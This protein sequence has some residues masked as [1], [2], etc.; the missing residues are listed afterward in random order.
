MPPPNCRYVRSLM[1]TARENAVRE[2]TVFPAPVFE[3]KV[4]FK[5]RRDATR[6]AKVV[7]TDQNHCEESSGPK[8][9]ILPVVPRDDASG[10]PPPPLAMKR[11]RRALRNFH[12]SPARQG[13][14]H[15][16]PTRTLHEPTSTGRRGGNPGTSVRRAGETRVQI[17]TAGTLAWTECAH[18]ACQQSKM[19]PAQG[20]MAIR[21]AFSYWWRLGIQASGTGTSRVCNNRAGGTACIDFGCGSVAA[22]DMAVRTTCDRTPIVIQVQPRGGFDTPR[23]RRGQVQGT[24]REYRR[25]GQGRNLSELDALQG[26]KNSKRADR[27]RADAGAV[28]LENSA[29]F[30]VREFEG[31]DLP[32]ISPT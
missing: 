13:R 21:P 25:Q 16:S 19:A 18:F 30:G 9:S 28:E 31:S 12:R 6:E 17:E 10:W 26:R 11:K 1:H 22:L 15:R 4:S 32:Y 8:Q 27:A 3:G 23:A 2:H 14:I 29:R 20:A 7:S 24:G 5:T